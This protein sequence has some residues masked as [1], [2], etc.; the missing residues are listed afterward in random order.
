METSSIYS[1]SREEGG[2]AGA[3]SLRL[4]SVQALAPFARVG[5]DA[6]EAFHFEL[7]RGEDASPIVRSDCR[8]P[9]AKSTRRTGHPLHRSAG[10]IKARATPPS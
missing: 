9:F 10:E 6:A 2:I 8:P 5:R 1:I 4:R 7:A 3:P